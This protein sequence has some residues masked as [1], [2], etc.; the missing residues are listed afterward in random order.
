MDREVEVTDDTRTVIAGPT[1]KGPAFVPTAVGSQGSLDRVFGSGAQTTYAAR[2]QIRQG[3]VP[4][5]VRV[6]ETAPWNPSALFLGLEDPGGVEEGDLY[7]AAGA[8]DFV[9]AAILSVDRDGVSN[10]A[11]VG[12]YDNL[13]IVLEN[14]SGAVV[15]ELAVSMDP[16]SP[17]YFG[18]L[19]PDKLDGVNLHANFVDTQ[20]TL[21]GNAVRSRFVESG[22]LDLS[23]QGPDRATTPWVLSQSDLREGRQRLFRFHLLSEGENRN[24]KVSIANIRENTF[25]VLVRDFTDSDLGPEVLE[26]YQGLTL[27]RDSEDFIAR[28]IGNDTEFFEDGDLVS[29]RGQFDVQSDFVRVEMSGLRIPQSARP[30]GFEGYREPAV[31]PQGVAIPEMPVVSNRSGIEEVVLGDRRRSIYLGTDLSNTQSRGFLNPIP[32]GTRKQDDYVLEPILG[33]DLA[34]SD[35]RER[36]FTLAFQGGYEGSDPY[37]DPAYG[38]DVT[39]SNVQGLDC[40]SFDAPGTQAYEA[41]FD[42]IRDPTTFGMAHL[43]TPAVIAEDHPAVVNLGQTLCRDREDAVYTFQTS[44]A[45]TPAADVVDTDVFGGSFSAAYYQWFEDDVSWDVPLGDLVPAVFAQNDNTSTPAKAPAGLERGR[46]P[47]VSVKEALTQS[48]RERLLGAGINC[49]TEKRGF[50]VAVGNKTL[51]PDGAFSNLNVRRGV[52]FVKFVAQSAARELIF[53]PNTEESRQR[54]QSEIESALEPISRRGGI[55]QFRVSVSGERNQVRGSV[56][57]QF[58][59]VVERVAIDFAVRRNEIVFV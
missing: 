22:S 11:A 26:E 9:V 48:E 21:R 10:A 14:A 34:D 17:R 35:V 20:V 44:H 30:Y 55:R 53:E 6:L 15:D 27:D 56:L 24:V 4:R 13:D 2:E 25:D 23:G 54:L 36:K 59:D 29:S 50:L 39:P 37:K 46:I 1:P 41:A 12:S 31:R 38:D 42:G 32:S 49:A 28:Q 8:T 51:R 57:L 40:S 18:E 19:L 7:E 16:G 33:Q 43:S 58:Q 3:G 52:N 5:V 47:S 45:N